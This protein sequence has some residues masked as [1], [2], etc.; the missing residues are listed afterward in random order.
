MSFIKTDFGPIGTLT[1]ARRGWLNPKQNLPSLIDKYEFKNDIGKPSVQ[2]AKFNPDPH[3]LDEERGLKEITPR[4]HVSSQ[5]MKNYIDLKLAEVN[6]LLKAPDLADDHEL[7]LGARATALQHWKCQVE[8]DGYQGSV[9]QEFKKD[10]V[11]WLRGFGKAEDIKRT[12]WGVEAVP[13]EEVEAYVTSIFNTKF[14]FIELIQS[15]IL[16][17]EYGGGLQGVNE[18]YL[19]FKYIVRGG[20]EDADEAD[21]LPDYVE[22]FKTLQE[23]DLK[24]RAAINQKK[25]LSAFSKLNL[26]YDSSYTDEEKEHIIGLKNALKFITPNEDDGYFEQLRHNNQLLVSARLDE[27]KKQTES[28]VEE[29]RQRNTLNLL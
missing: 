14:D 22:Y 28:Y 23:Q 27:I 8:K 16:K 25:D 26:R 21:Y 1:P 6:Q 7:L 2:K 12:P 4:K 19:Y 17:A 29:A 15:L 11:A 13:D 18:H 20:W 10:F 9:D 3:E 24:D 5:T